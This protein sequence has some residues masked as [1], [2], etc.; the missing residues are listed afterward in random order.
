MAHYPELRYLKKPTNWLHKRMDSL[1]E[2]GCDERTR[3]WVSESLGTVSFLGGVATVGF[4]PPVGAMAITFGACSVLC[5]MAGDAITTGKIRAFAV[6]FGDLMGLADRMTR[7]KLEEDEFGDLVHVKKEDAPIQKSSLARAA[8]F[9]SPEEAFEANFLEYNKREIALYLNSIPPSIDENGRETYEARLDEYIEMCSSVFHDEDSEYYELLDAIGQQVPVL[10][11]QVTPVGYIPPALTPTRLVPPTVLQ[12][13]DND[14]VHQVPTSWQV[15]G[16]QNFNKQVVE[17]G[18]QR[19]IKTWHECTLTVAGQGA[20]KTEMY[21]WV[22]YL[23]AQLGV[24][25][26]YI[27]LATKPQDLGRKWEGHTRCIRTDLRKIANPT[28]AEAVVSETHHLIQEFDHTTG[29]KLLIVDE[30][31]IIFLKTHKYAKLMKP[32]VEE[33]TALIGDLN[34]AGGKENASVHVLVQVL[35]AGSLTQNILPIL[36]SLRLNFITVAP[37]QSAEAKDRDQKISTNAQAH[38]SVIDNYGSDYRKIPSGLG[39]SRVVNLD[40]R[41]SPCGSKDDLKIQIQ[42]SASASQPE[43]QKKTATP[44]MDRVIEALEDGGF[45]DLWTFANYLE[46]VDGESKRRLIALVADHIEKYNL[47]VG[48]QVSVYAKEEG[49]S[50][51]DARYSQPDLKQKL[52]D[53]YALTGNRCCI[54]QKKTDLEAHHLRYLSGEDTPGKNMVPLCEECHDEAHK[55]KNWVSNSD[56]IWAAHQLEHFENKIRMGLNFLT[57]PSQ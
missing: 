45:T 35:K 33:L 18:Y 51:Y 49:F 39:D 3:V 17:S 7:S 21:F 57:S 50:R 1:G 31:N 29:K 6:T 12:E 40:G 14:T 34:S 26:F 52:K 32:M 5:A 53:T 22:T 36:K 23:A 30:G 47:P 28:D 11:Q 46:I 27:N 41:W 16:G 43:A 55:P 13:P 38:Q 54:C 44:K 25:V 19:M 10:S 4:M 8:E 37:G 42:D 20:G 2:K 9:L 56:D 15:G 48:E 24:K